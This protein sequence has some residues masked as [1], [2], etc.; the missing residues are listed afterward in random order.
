M[1]WYRAR[2]QNVRFVA[3]SDGHQWVRSNLQDVAVSDGDARFDMAVLII[4]HAAVG[5]AVYKRLT[6]FAAIG[7]GGS[8]EAHSRPSFLVS[9]FSHAFRH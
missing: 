4:Y 9:T 5:I 2:Y 8:V 6:C 7:G 3:C 1:N